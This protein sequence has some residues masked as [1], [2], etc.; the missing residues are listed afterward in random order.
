MAFRTAGFLAGV[1]GFWASAAVVDR[2]CFFGGGSGDVSSAASA[3]AGCFEAAT[4]VDRRRVFLGGGDGD[5]SSAASDVAG[6]FAAGAVADRSVVFF[7]GGD[8]DVSSPA[9]EVAGCCDLA[10]AVDRMRFFGGGDGDV[11]CT[12]GRLRVVGVERAGATAPRL[13]LRVCARVTRGVREGPPEAA[14]APDALR[15]GEL[16]G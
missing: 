3:V 13:R 4:V 1:I 6:R 10:A 5:V 7:G 16:V 9:S 14:D 11:S 12:V 15:A 8:G 2:R